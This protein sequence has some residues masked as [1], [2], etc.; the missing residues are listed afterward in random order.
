MKT[1]L[2]WLV[3]ALMTLGC[4]PKKEEAFAQISYE[5]DNAPLSTSHEPLE[6]RVKF[7]P[8]QLNDYERSFTDTSKIPGQNKAK[9]IIK[10]GNISIKV[11]RLEVAKKRLD[12]VLNTNL[13]YYEKED[14]ENNDYRSAYTLK[15]RIPS[16][17]FESF[18][19]AAEKA[20]GEVIYKSINARDVTEDYTDTEIRLTSK[21][22]FRQRYNELLTRAG[23]V[24]DILAIEENI[25]VLQEEIESQEG[26][27]HYLNDQVAYSTLDITL[28]TLKQNSGKIKET[29]NQ[30]AKG[31]VA[32]GWQT[33]LNFLLWCIQQWPWFL[34][35]LSIFIICI[36]LWKRRSNRQN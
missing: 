15:V 13:A 18:V 36:R 16:T 7:L 34:F 4:Q 27:L 35:G 24:V 22:L 25:R 26:H 21:R 1:Q 28:F 30:L 14:Y 17:R 31:S 3:L 20:D 9:K 29:F 23:K 33:I 19:C 8:P 10:D 2:T 6:D 11:P 32:V 12:S 5:S